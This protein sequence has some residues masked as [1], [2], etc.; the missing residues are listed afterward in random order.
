MFWD[1]LIRR[2]RRDNRQLGHRLL[3]GAAGYV[4]VAPSRPRRSRVSLV[5]LMVAVGVLLALAVATGRVQAA[6]V[7]PDDTG[8]ATVVAESTVH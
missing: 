1:D 5:L 4:A 7:W 6:T 2:W 8:T 3:A